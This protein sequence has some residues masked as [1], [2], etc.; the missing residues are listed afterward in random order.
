MAGIQ[1]DPQRPGFRH[2]VIRPEPGGGLTSARA[3]CD[4]LH[5][6]IR[7]EWVWGAAEGRLTLNVEIP[8][9]TTATIH[10]PAAADSRV[11][12]TAGAREAAGSLRPARREN[13]AAV[14]EVGSGSYQFVVTRP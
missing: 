7:S 6:P 4:S 10:V 14:F 9:N 13:G 2:I 3:R 1:P 5:G 12:E 8:A 11:E